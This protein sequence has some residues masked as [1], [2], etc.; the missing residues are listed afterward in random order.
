MATLER[1]AAA[2]REGASQRPGAAGAPPPERANES[3]VLP[4][5]AA[6][7]LVLFAAIGTFLL[8]PFFFDLGP[9]GIAA[10]EI[11]FIGT[12]VLLAARQQG[13]LAGIGLTRP[14]A[15]D[16]VGGALVGLSGWTFLAG[17]V[18]PLQERIAPTPPELERALEGVAAPNLAALLA[19]AVVPAICEE[20]LVRGGLAFAL[21]RA[22]GRFAAVFGS[23]LAFGVLHASP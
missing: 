23:A 17:V 6:L 7:L 16:V 22:L 18:L 21:D 9:A 10:S 13:G 2:T 14:R 5:R 11:L 12:P 20:L 1:G 19:I 4:V 15:R 3:Y 8:G